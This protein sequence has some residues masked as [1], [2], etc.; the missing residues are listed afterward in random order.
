MRV[1][2]ITSGYLNT[3]KNSIQKKNYE[4]RNDVTSFFPLQSGQ[5]MNFIGLGKYV[6]ALFGDAEAI[7]QIIKDKAIKE[8]INTFVDQIDRNLNKRNIL[9]NNGRI[10]GFEEYY[11][12]NAGEKLLRKVEFNNNNSV[13]TVTTFEYVPNSQNNLINRTFNY[14]NQGKLQWETR[15]K[16]DGRNIVETTNYDPNGKFL[17]KTMYGSDYDGSYT[18]DYDIE[19]NVLRYAKRKH[20]ENMYVIELEDYNPKSP[21]FGKIQVLDED[22]N[23]F[24]VIK[25]EKREGFF[26]PFEVKYYPNGKFKSEAQ[27]NMANGVGYEGVHDK[28]EVYESGALKYLDKPY[29]KGY[30]M[31]YENGNLMEEKTVTTWYTGTHSSISDISIVRY[32][33][34]GKT[35]IKTSSSCP[36]D[37]WVTGSYSRNE[38]I[39]YTPD[40]RMVK[41]VYVCS[42]KEYKR[43]NYIVNFDDNGNISEIIN[44]SDFD[45]SKP[46]FKAGNNIGDFD[47]E[48]QAIYSKWS[49][50]NKK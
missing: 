28:R 3:Q 7:G 49:N 40:G 37:T 5:N 36:K 20:R 17:H 2:P 21:Y 15:Y 31:Y 9:S 50:I 33:E 1:S 30:K 6:K 12:S 10:K 44:Y 41:R 8:G 47:S 19:G 29:G 26:A 14:D 48:T 34:D 13:K 27:C 22:L 25:Y 43:S 32:A 24:E 23:L 42:E 39:D 18:R 16:Y 11:N 4:T 35:V 46:N 38:E 45:Y